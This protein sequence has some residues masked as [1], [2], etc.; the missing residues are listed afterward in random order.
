MKSIVYIDSTISLNYKSCLFHLFSS[1]FHSSFT[2][3]SSFEEIDSNQFSIFTK[4]TNYEANVVSSNYIDDYGIVIDSTNVVINNLNYSFLS[5]AGFIIILGPDN[6][7][8][9]DFL[10]SLKVHKYN[11]LYGA[12]ASEAVEAKSILLAEFDQL[13][14]V[15]EEIIQK[16]LCVEEIDVLCPYRFN[17]LLYQKLFSDLNIKLNFHVPS[18]SQYQLLLSNAKSFIGGISH[19]V[20]IDISPEKPGGEIISISD[21]AEKLSQL[22]SQSKNRPKPDKDKFT[23]N[24][25]CFNP[26]YLFKDLVDRFVDIGC[27]HSDFPLPNADS[28]IWMRPQ[29]IWHIEFLL[30]GEENVEISQKYKETFKSLNS[31]LDLNRIKSRSVAI[32]HGTCFEPLYQFNFT[33]LTKS[34]SEI[35]RVVGVCEFE[36]CYG[37]SASFANKA[38]FKFVPIGYDHLLFS[39]GFIKTETKKPRSKLKIGFVGRAYGTTNKTTLMRSKLAE[40]KGYRKGGDFLFD[41]GLRLKSLGIDI[42][43]H[44][45]GQNWEELVDKLNE[46]GIANKY[47]ARDKDLTYKDYPKVYGEFDVLLVSARCEGGPVSAIEALSLGVRVVGTD[48]GVIRHLADNLDADTCSVFSYDRKWH[49][50]DIDAAV[51]ALKKIYEM[52]LSFSDRKKVRDQV[53]DLTTERWCSSI[54]T[55][56]QKLITGI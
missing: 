13:P 34:L 50:A 1:R 54:F 38:N 14:S 19:T 35:S 2:L 26:T 11:G 17:S 12:L 49:I 18:Y 16:N 48:V 51:V 42:E 25:V 6:S 43:I 5:G 7:K 37:P 53:F 30:S 45:L 27:V 55:E 46:Y 40:P 10:R 36:E 44:I 3:S 29:E 4:A 28:Y 24:I 15:Y 8:L 20:K 52:E 39:E 32:H 21:F 9:L 33:N 56:A 22:V 41:I 23:I 31:S 47:Y